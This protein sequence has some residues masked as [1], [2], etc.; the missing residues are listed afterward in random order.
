MSF[1]KVLR[2]PS[3]FFLWIG[4]II[5]QFGDRF[6]PMAL[7][8]LI[9]KRAPG[10]AFELAKLF[11]FIAIPAFVVGPIAGVYCDRWNRK[12]T[13][14]ISDIVRGVLLL[15]I[16]LYWLIVP[17]LQPIFPVYILVFIMFSATRFFI[18]A[19]MS[20]VP[21]LVP[22]DKLLE[23]NSLIH[24]TG[25]I[26]AALGFGLGG[27]LI[28]VPSVGVKGALLIDAATFFISA[29]LLYFIK[30]DKQLP[31]ARENIY[32]FG[33]HV[34]EIIRTTV[35]A[36]IKDGIRYLL[37]HR[38][39][40]FIIAFLF[41][42]ASGVGASQAVLIVFIQ[43]TFE[44]VTKE[45]GLLA[46]FCGAGLF[47]GTMIYGKFGNRFSKTR[48]I[49]LGLILAGMFLVEFIILVGVLANFFMAAVITFL[50][51]AAVSPIIISSNTIVH[52]LIPDE[53]RGRV[54]SSIEAVINLA[55]VIFMIAV[56]KLAGF[57]DA[58]YILVAVGAV[59]V[60]VG[61]LGLRAKI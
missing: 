25:M 47:C 27:I 39:M 1:R 61:I 18:P 17:N 43:N 26:A 5:S 9:Y 58:S 30:I 60:Y 52:E 41:I 44:S 7:I 42:L 16:F 22:Q 6:A 23:A 11:L 49:F 54:F 56:S 12:Y 53:L 13:M 55:Y 31:H 59:F 38:K 29:V 15:L 2:E 4:Q 32:A 24:T 50:F 19:K 33:R 3:F 48:A 46:M 37:S 40:N 36:E 8:G 51:G 28:A 10:S 34:K 35:V 21:D 14:I 57:V 20:I 45:L